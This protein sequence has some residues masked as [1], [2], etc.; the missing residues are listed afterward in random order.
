MSFVTAIPVAIKLAGMLRDGYVFVRDHPDEVQQAMDDAAKAAAAAKRLAGDARDQLQIDER[1]AKAKS[2]ADRARAKASSTATG[3]RAWRSADPE[4]VKAELEARKTIALARHTVLASADMSLPLTKLSRRLET[5]DLAALE[6]D[7]RILDAPGCFVIA[8]Y[9]RIDLDHD[10]ADYEEVYV[11]KAE[12]VGDGIAEAISRAGNPDVYADVK[13][14]R[15]VHVFVFNC[16]VSELKYRCN[17][18]IEV[19]D[20]LSSY[21]MPIE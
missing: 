2:A 15:N 20:A 4:A 3:L 1:V 13:F 5:D 9:P 21:N 19:F 14:K 8:T 12:V 7:L 6:A 17:A 18:L 16:D 11:G 10:L